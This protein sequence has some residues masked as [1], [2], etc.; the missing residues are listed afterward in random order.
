MANRSSLRGGIAVK[1]QPETELVSRGSCHGCGQAVNRARAAGR[2]PRAC[3]DTRRP[4]DRMCDPQEGD[5]DLGLDARR[6]LGFNPHDE[7]VRA[8]LVR[9]PREYL[10]P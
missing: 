1:S 4:L 2:A 7:E 6:F 5:A 3:S 8:A 9:L 10:Y